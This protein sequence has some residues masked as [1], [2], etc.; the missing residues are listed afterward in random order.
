M[1]YLQLS[2]PAIISV[3]RVGYRVRPLFVSHPEVSHRRYD[4]AMQKLQQDIRKQVKDKNFSQRQISD[5]MW[6]LFNPDYQ[7]ESVPIHTHVG[8]KLI[9]GAF[10]RVRFSLEGY[11]FTFLPAFNHF[12]MESKLDRADSDLRFERIVTGFF[13]QQ[14]KRPEQDLNPEAY[15]TEKGEFTAPI[16]FSL[17]MKSP[18]FSFEANGFNFY[19]QIMGASDFDGEDELARVGSDLN[20]HFPDRLMS[21][22]YR[23][24]EVDRLKRRMYQ[25]DKVAIA[26]VGPSGCGKTALIHQA[27]SQY[28]SEH[29]STKNR[30]PKVYFVDPTRVIAGMSIVGQWQRRLES[31]LEVF[32]TRL[33]T[34][35]DI[36][37]TDILYVDNPVALLRIGKSAQNDLTL[38][39]VIKPDLKEREFSMV[40]ESTPEAWAK[41]QEM[42]R[43]FAD[44]FQ[45]I[46]LEPAD[47]STSLNMMMRQRALLEQQFECQ[48][49]NDALML[50][51]DEQQSHRSQEVLPGRVVKI[52]AQLATRFQKRLITLDDMQAQLRAVTHY[53]RDMLDHEVTLSHACVSQYFSER[54]IAQPDAVACLTDVVCRIKARL[55]DPESPL[56]ALLFLGPTGVGKT[57]AAKLMAQ[58]LFDDEDALIRFDMNEYIDAY[59]VSR[60]IGDHWNPEGQLTSQVRYRPNCVLLLDEI[61]KADPSIHDLLLQLL[62]EGRLTDALG[63]TTDFSQCI[64]IMTSNL[65]ARATASSVG[66]TARSQSDESATYEA[67]VE[68]FFRPELINRMDQLVVFHSLTRSVMGDIARLQ[69]KRL[70]QRDGFVRRT[71]MLDIADHLID[72]VVGESLDVSLGARGLKRHI[73]KT[74][75]QLTADQLLDLPV[76][77]PVVLRL[78]YFDRG[79][80]PVVYPLY[81]DELHVFDKS[82]P[83]PNRPAL[84]KW[85][86]MADE[87]QP[88]LQQLDAYRDSTTLSDTIAASCLQL[89]DELFV[90][91]T[92]IE[93]RVWILQE[94]STHLSIA[95]SRVKKNVSSPVDVRHCRVHINDLQAQMDLHEYLFDLYKQAEAVN[96]DD[97][98]YQQL[99]QHIDSIRYVVMAVISGRNGITV[100]HCRSLISREGLSEL[101]YLVN[102]YQQ[103]VTVDETCVLESGDAWL[104]ISTPGVYD[105]LQYESGIHL[106]YR[107]LKTPLPVVCH[108]LEV[109]GQPVSDW[110]QSYACQESYTIQRL[111]SLAES[112]D[113]KTKDIVTDIRTGLIAMSPLS[114]HSVNTLLRYLQRA[115][116]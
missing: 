106:F 77:Q 9:S 46:R 64:I 8:S 51:L 108:V 81:Q 111:Y 61:E 23:D 5:F 4:R 107:Q 87:V 22:F 73:E 25:K 12:Y 91:K 68:K 78:T 65:G 19:E 114:E 54:L 45:V 72:H 97:V 56:A 89:R 103:L 93:D 47:A 13:R 14:K 7:Y 79:F 34:V 20:E 50:L 90:L 52:L 88:L 110:L 16:D 104:V 83:L 1:A 113:A 76:E 75:T 70:L 109:P 116:Q 2:F 24:E 11:R 28:L 17:D 94:Q 115:R 36:G 29:L 43:S 53:K 101:Q 33:K 85:S 26:L 84:E 96:G 30:C 57:E 18:Q 39:D 41:V 112:G 37:D 21:A 40:V 58:Y 98:E 60:L 67:E 80:Y 32:K 82:N 27:V 10:S 99:K 3:S 49:D 95:R 100:L 63:K 74:L 59:G 38:A 44:L 102:F 71:T 48:F 35:F 69:L 55:S 92:K 66:F 15:Y 86:L 6:L 42:D 31:M 62:D 105:W